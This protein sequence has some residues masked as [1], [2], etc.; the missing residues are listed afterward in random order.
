MIENAGAFL[1]RIETAV[2]PHEVHSKFVSFIPRLVADERRRRIFS[3]LAQK[4]QIDTRYSVVSPHEDPELLDVEGFYRL[5]RFPS[6]AA[7]M[8]KYERHAL[9]LV[10]E[11]VRRLL[12]SVNDRREITHLIITSCT[13]FYAPG[14]DLELQRHFGLRSDLERM[15]IGFMGC[16]AGVNALKAAAQ[17]VRASLAYQPAKVL[18]VNLELCSLHLQQSDDPEQLMAFLQFADGCAA[19]LITSEPYGLRLDR[20]KAA[21]M[22]EARELIRWHVGDGGFQMVLSGEVP[23]AIGQELPRVWPQIVTENERRG[24]SLWAVHPGGRS[25]LDAVQTALR[26]SDDEMKVSREVLRRYGNMS[27]ATLMFVLKILLDDGRRYGSG[28]AMAFGPGLTV[29]TLLFHKQ[30]Q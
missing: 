8:Q 24:L 9:G 2:P 27:S 3:R 29:E 26:L 15:M 30:S 11:P 7:R 17:I 4:C 14:L 20:F 6:T 1:N 10:E 28:A 25:V 19:S 13:G 5:G 12:S 21:V 18:I 16:Y 22:P 23:R